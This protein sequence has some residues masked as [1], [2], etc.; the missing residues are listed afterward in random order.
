MQY[1]SV[2]T[3]FFYT[4]PPF[5]SDKLKSKKGLSRKDRTNGNSYTNMTNT[6]SVFSSVR[7][8]NA[9]PTDV[10]MI[11]RSTARSSRKQKSFS[12]KRETKVTG[13]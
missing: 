5:Q 4:L 11:A 2:E 1:S 12:S 10:D 9:M 6:T 8:V 13:N 7:D 3:E